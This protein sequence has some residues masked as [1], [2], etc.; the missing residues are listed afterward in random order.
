MTIFYGALIVISFIVAFLLS[1]ILIKSEGFGLHVED[2]KTNL[3]VL[4]KQRVELDYDLQNGIITEKEYESAIS[5]L[6]Y[7]YLD[8]KNDSKPP[9]SSV[10]SHKYI[11]VSLFILC[12]T[13]ALGL[14]LI[15]GNVD[16]LR[17]EKSPADSIS[18][19]THQEFVEMTANLSKHLENNS[20]DLKGWIM[21]GRAYAILNDYKNAS[22]SWREA[23]GLAPDNLELRVSLAEALVL[24]KQ[25]GFSEEAN[26]LVRQV[27]EV[28][29]LH[30]KGLAL[31]GGIEYSRKN[32]LGAAE[33]WQKLLILVKDDLEYSRSIEESIRDAENK[34]KRSSINLLLRGTVRLADELLNKLPSSYSVFIVV[35]QDS[36]SLMPLIVDKIKV[37][38]LPYSFELDNTNIMQ[39]RI[40]SESAGNLYQITSFVSKTDRVDD[41]IG[42]VIG[43]TL[44]TKLQQSG[45][46]LILSEK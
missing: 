36:G 40:R 23:L 42:T 9:K 31:A 20:G 2:E 38:D 46:E 30:Q 17:V 39:G 1:R 28:D 41:K 19:I 18:S 6:A 14:Y 21:L 8:E 24:L 26:Q 5:D 35:R 15:F 16:G 34:A 29:P 12:P 11:A 13:V 3:S 45:I 25:G 7:R 33:I 43:N 37:R 10:A 22:E 32:Y 44:K 27:L 4:R